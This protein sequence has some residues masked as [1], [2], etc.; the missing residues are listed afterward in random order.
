MEIRVEFSLGKK[1][2]PLYLLNGSPSA[3]K[4]Y[5]N[6]SI[7]A[8]SATRNSPS[9]HTGCGGA[10]RHTPVFYGLGTSA[11]SPAKGRL[12]NSFTITLSANLSTAHFGAR[13]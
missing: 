12:L 13:H 10:G 11:S 6:E 1:I 9:P 4:C 5:L 7:E 3:Q 8:T 2:D